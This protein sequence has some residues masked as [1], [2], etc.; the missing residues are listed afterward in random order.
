[1]ASQPVRALA[2]A[3]EDEEPLLNDAEARVL[4]SELEHMSP[5][6]ILSWA[7]G[8]FGPHIAASSSFQTQSMPL[9]HMISRV[10]P[11]MPILFLDTGFHFQET[12]EFRDRITREW[13]L[14]V[15][16]LRHPGGNA[17]FVEQ[18]G[19]LYER[20]PDLCC[21]LNK[22]VPLTAAFRRYRV[23]VAG[24]RRD[25]TE[26]RSGTRVISIRSDGVV[27]ICPI[28]A[29]TGRD[30]T[31]YLNR[32][33]LPVHPLLSK[34][35]LSVGCAPCTRSAYDSERSGRWAGTSKTECGLHEGPEPRTHVDDQAAPAPERS[36]DPK[37]S[38]GAENKSVTKPGDIGVF[39]Q[40]NVDFLN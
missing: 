6:D 17:A 11:A 37:R 28:A 19:R 5:E 22:V 36:G 9:L 23:W 13:G 31:R 38:G 30:I 35:Y 25:Q 7:Y 16:D 40:N 21:R 20:D 15:L 26:N 27:K 10:V 12:L 3:A 34:G 4:E 24:I 18:Y 32:Y 29:W 1:M 39:L 33:D 14:N 8:L 2:P